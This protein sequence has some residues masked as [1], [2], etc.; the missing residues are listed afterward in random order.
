MLQE[1]T[2]KNLAIIKE[3]TVNFHHQLNILTGETG[4]GKS[5]II[6]A[7]G[8]ICGAKAP[9]ELIRS[10]E[11]SMEVQAL[12]ENLHPELCQLLREQDIDCD[13][14]QLIIRRV[15]N[16][17][18]QNKVYVNAA[19]QPVAFL[20][21]LADHLVT[22]HAQNHH[23]MLLQPARH[24]SFLDAFLEAPQ[25]LETYREHYQDYRR[26]RRH[27][28]EAASRVREARQR[29]DF[30]QGQLEE[31]DSARLQPGEDEELENQL[32]VLTHAQDIV[33][34][35]QQVYDALEEADDAILARLA[36]VK[37]QLVSLTRFDNDFHSYLSELE[38]AVTTI[39]DISAVAGQK[40]QEI[41]AD[42]KQLAIV[43]GR[44]RL[45]DSLKLKY[46]TTVQ[47]ILEYGEELRAEQSELEQSLDLEKLQ[48]D[49][50]EALA[51]AMDSGRQLSA[52]RQKAAAYITSSI[53]QHL[54]QLHM[55]N[56]R[57]EVSMT[58]LDE[59]AEEGLEQ[60]E[61]LLSANKGESL[62]PLAKVASGGEMSRI[63]LAIKGAL[64]ERE[65]HA[66]T[67]VFDEVDTGV[68]GA[69]AEMVG[70]KLKELARRHQV[71]VITHLP[72]V[73]VQGDQNYRITKITSG[74]ATM[75]RVDALDHEEKVAEIARILS[76]VDITAESLSHARR[77]MDQLE[78]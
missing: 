49:S 35:C 42:E 29:L 56:C 16:V 63:M 78:S 14:D 25:Q 47:A 19:M 1:L 37:R 73:A 20:K 32:R 64:A 18:G 39:T 60:V 62:K 67:M 41:E 53:L 26:K 3:V 50:E 21:T 2:I 76:G 61:F 28:D 44:I 54:N 10:G 34:L 17:N 68:S 40:A 43:E 72:Q 36:Q 59:P 15:V 11:E 70:K 46:G 4:A 65:T 9:K 58:S 57:F 51:K 27:Y 12:F 66:A 69:V 7:L 5:I 6:D 33:D 24:V 38:G 75:T 31:I 48:A 55:K 22:I 13:D 45:I 77:Y 71:M 74:N 52:Q 8:L 23:Q 30:I